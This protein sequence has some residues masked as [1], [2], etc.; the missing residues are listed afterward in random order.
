MY[1]D[2]IHECTITLCS[3]EINLPFFHIK[4]YS[5]EAS[6]HAVNMQKM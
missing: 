2:V 6:F 4:V 5:L 3:L 1:C